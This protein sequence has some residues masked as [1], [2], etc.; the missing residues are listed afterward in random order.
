[1]KQ[2]RST[3]LSRDLKKSLENYKKIQAKTAE[4]K[5]VSEQLTA[6]KTLTQARKIVYGEKKKTNAKYRGW[7]WK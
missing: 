3:W 2:V 6:A 4:S 5:G 7:S 1:M